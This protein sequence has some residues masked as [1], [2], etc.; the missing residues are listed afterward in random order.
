MLKTLEAIK[1]FVKTKSCHIDYPLFRLHYQVTVCGILAFC[2]ILTANVLFGE[3]MKCNGNVDSSEKF[4]DNMC[5]SRGTFTTYQHYRNSFTHA[6]VMSLLPKALNGSV[7]Y[8][9]ITYDTV[10]KYEDQLERTL[11]S[12]NSI[13]YMYN[14]MPVP[15]DEQQSN[16]NQ[17]F[18]H[19]YYQYMPLIL[20]IQAVFFYFPHYLWKCWENGVINSIT[21]L[22]HDNRLDPSNYI[23][24]N[25]HIITYLQN[26]FT[27]QKSLIYKY[28][29]CQCLL[30]LNIVCQAIVLDILFNWG[31][32]NYGIDVLRYWFGDMNLY[33]FMNRH[34]Q[35]DPDLNNPMDYV[36]PKV[37]QCS[38]QYLSPGGKDIQ[39]LHFMCVLPLNLL[40][41]KFFL[42]LW[43]WLVILTIVTIIHIIFDS[44]Y[45][46][47]PAVRKYLFNR[48]FGPYL[49]SDNLHWSSLPELFLL[50]LIGS[51]TDKF[52]FSTLLVRL[53][54]ENRALSP[55]EFQSLV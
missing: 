5:F 14:G 33:G 28:Y 10:L 8:E 6:F 16:L 38:I 42:L 23:D 24:A 32:I 11:R 17:V 55:S 47:T 12:K 15:S 39:D 37:T 2:L 49:S 36:F 27:Y 43:F 54:K 50:D 13:L 46:T 4:Y 40:N 3:T 1:S 35:L 52:A 21:K 18:W 29:F 22:L 19:R 31:F 34:G 51:N 44:I 25:H 9:E 20:F 41:D 30:F 45:L 7:K 26:C 48:K 53:N